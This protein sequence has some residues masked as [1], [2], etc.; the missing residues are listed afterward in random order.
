[1]S[2]EYGLMPDGTVDVGALLELIRETRLVEPDSLGPWLDHL[3]RPPASRSSG[4][5]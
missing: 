4:P 1:M 5:S 2:G 3:A